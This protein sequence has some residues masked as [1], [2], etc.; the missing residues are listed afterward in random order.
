M[1]DEEHKLTPEEEQEIM[2]MLESA[3]NAANKPHKPRSTKYTPKNH[4]QRGQLNDAIIN[5][6]D[7]FLNCFLMLG[8][9]TNGSPTII[10]DADSELESRALSDLL[11]EFVQKTMFKLGDVI[12]QELEDDGGDDEEDTEY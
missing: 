9:D 6:M 5:R 4:K 3:A 8:F 11:Q 2:K 1:M 12:S 7:E 10:I